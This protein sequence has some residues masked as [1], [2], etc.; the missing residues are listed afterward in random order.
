MLQLRLSPVRL[1]LQ[2]FG[3][4]V[5][6]IPPRSVLSGGSGGSGG[7]GDSAGN[8]DSVLD[9]FSVDLTALAHRG[10]LDPLIGR[11]DEMDRALQI[12]C[13]PTATARR[14]ARLMG[15]LIILTYLYR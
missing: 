3:S 8:N 15:K 14:P 1:L 2:R 10:A 7:S 9:Q 6:G 11:E 13:P 5:S 12:L 4:S